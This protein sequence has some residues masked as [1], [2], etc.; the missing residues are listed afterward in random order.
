MIK[1]LCGFSCC[2]FMGLAEK[3]LLAYGGGVMQILRA[4]NRMETKKIA[5][6]LAKSVHALPRGEGALVVALDGELGSGKTA[7][8]QYLAHALGVR[9]RVTSPTFVVMKIYPLSHRRT[10]SFDRL[11]HIDCYRLTAPRDLLALGFANLVND[12]AN[13]IAIEW[14]ERIKKILPARAIHIAFSVGAHPRERIIRV[15]GKINAPSRQRRGNTLEYEYERA[16]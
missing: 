7:F 2:F 16:V 3:I 15:D 10:D 1:R 11:I 8:A 6:A 12:S 4:Y 14:A 5:Q 9:E 13:L